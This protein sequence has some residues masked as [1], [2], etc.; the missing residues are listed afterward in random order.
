MS[1]R[2]IILALFLTLLVVVAA[3]YFGP[4]RP[5]RVE[6][7]GTGYSLFHKAPRSHEGEGPAEIY[8]CFK[9][10]EGEIPD[11]KAWLLGRVKKNQDWVRLPSA[12][13]ESNR[14][15]CDLAMVFEIP[16][17]PPTTRYYYRFE[18]QGGGGPDVWL[19]R[20][21]GEPMM[22]KFKG[23]VPPWIWISHV[24]AMFGGFFVLILTAF[25]AVPLVKGKEDMGVAKRLARWAW[26][27]L[28][29]GGVPLG[30]AM[31]FYAFEV[32]WEAFPF[33]GDV[34]DNK[35]QVALILWGIA[36]LGLSG[37]RGRKAGIFTLIAALLVLGIFLIPHSLQL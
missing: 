25:Y 6:T 31:N 2:R 21:G 12:R 32:Y 7:S 24:V 11:L 18:I 4:N 13:T 28:F 10:S 8:L 23:V 5:Y 35:T 30:M 33:G 3:R 16:H 1:V 15:D 34:T 9:R 37:R 22:I 29:I 26:A 19:T 20:E 36:A 14:E 17:H 27:L